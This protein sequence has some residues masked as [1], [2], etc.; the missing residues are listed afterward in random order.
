VVITPPGGLLSTDTENL[1]ISDET[2]GAQESPAS[3]GEGEE[4]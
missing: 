1:V 2:S 3:S 4:R